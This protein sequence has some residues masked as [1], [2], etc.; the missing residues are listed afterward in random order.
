MPKHIYSYRTKPHKTCAVVRY[1]AIG[2]AIQ[3]S[4]ILPWLKAQGFHITFY[5]APSGYEVLKHDPHI[6]ELVMQDVDIIPNPRLGEFWDAMAKKYTKFVNLSESVERT[7]LALPGNMNHTWSQEMRHKHLDRNYLQ[8]IH[9]IAGVPP[10]FMPKFHETLAE[11]YWAE[12]E[13]GA[14]GGA[15]VIAW[16]VAGS[17][18]HK[19]WPYLDVAMDA[20]LRE[21]PDVR[22]VLMGGE[23]EQALEAGWEEVSQ[24]HRRCGKWTIRQAI[25]FSKLADLVIGPE[26]GLMN[27]VSMEDV[28]KIVLLSHSSHNN[29]T[30]D[31]V[32]TQALA[33]AATSCYP[34]HRL[35]VNAEG[36]KHC[37]ESKDVPGIAACQADIRPEAMVSAIKGFLNSREERLAA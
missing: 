4:S 12:K 21:R 11:A 18:I 2:D 16:L 37:N 9:D 20:V 32:N 10:P 30:R 22:F 34:C 31:W 36:F 28:A 35:H 25:S 6:D 33:P 29:L 17:A 13:R 19:V 8:F 1:G 5:T 14:V 23:K 26:T 7:L 27:A 3:A 24:V 15:F